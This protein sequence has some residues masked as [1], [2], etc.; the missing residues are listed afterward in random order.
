MKVKNVVFSGFMAAI[1]SATGANAAISVAS[2]AYVDKFVGENGSVT[3]ELSGLKQTVTDNKT[4]TDNALDLKAN[5]TDVASIY[6]TKEFVGSLEGKDAETIVQYIEKKTSDIASG[7]A[8]SELTGRVGTAEGKITALETLTGENGQIAQDIAQAL[9]DA[10]ADATQKANAAQAAAEAKAAT[11]QAA[12]EAADGKAV[13][14][15][16]AANT[17]AAAITEITKVGGTIDTKAGKALDDAKEYVDSKIDKFSDETFSATAGQVESNR[18][19]I[20]GLVESVDA[21]DKAYKAADTTLQGN[22]DTLS[23]TVS[24]MD[25]AY[26]AADAG[27]DTAVKAAQA[28]ATQALADA[29]AASTAAGT[30]LTDAK[31]YAD[32]QDAAQTE[33][34]TAAYQLADT[35]LK[36][37]LEDYADDQAKA[38][39]DT[40]KL[41]ATA[42]VPEECVTENGSN[43]CVLTMTTAGTFAWTPLT[44]PVDE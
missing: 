32:T 40:L 28:D 35:N 31:N 25:T 8:F 10:K 4:A 30:A 26:K 23:A 14:A 20:A 37:D 12:A 42:P 19:A 29:A 22:I 17:N 1:L 36:S 11:A 27:L 24:D 2:K 43:M 39:A 34:I 7:T 5:A 13:A 33:T 9:S 18:Q 6:A 41:L 16:A 21:M 38:V 3:T 15:Q 44:Y